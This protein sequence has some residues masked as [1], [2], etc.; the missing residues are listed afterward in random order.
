MGSCPRLCFKMLAYLLLMLVLPFKLALPAALASGCVLSTSFW[1]SWVK[2]SSIPTRPDLQ[3][4]S[5]FICLVSCQSCGSPWLF[6]ASF[7][8]YGYFMSSN[9]CLFITFVLMKSGIAGSLPSS[10]WLNLPVLFPVLVWLAGL[11]GRWSPYGICGSLGAGVRS[12]I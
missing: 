8:I 9:S 10:S 3:I 6:I 2:N 7:L 1:N 4:F 12:L 11:A 5:F